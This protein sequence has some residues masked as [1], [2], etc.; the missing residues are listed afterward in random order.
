MRRKAGKATA[1]NLKH[2]TLVEYDRLKSSGVRFEVLWSK[3]P[4]ADDIEFVNS[5]YAQTPE[6]DTNGAALNWAT[7]TGKSNLIRMPVYSY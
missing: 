4:T 5:V 6:F 3:A 2:E 1:S 7:V